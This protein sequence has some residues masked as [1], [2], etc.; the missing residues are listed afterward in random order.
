M[1]CN[2]NFYE[3][4]EDKK[5]R[6]KREKNNTQQK[7]KKQQKYVEKRYK[8]RISR[9][10]A[11]MKETTDTY[12]PREYEV[13]TWTIRSHNG[14]DE[15]GNCTGKLCDGKSM[16]C[17]MCECPQYQRIIKEAKA[18]GRYSVECFGCMTCIKDSPTKNWGNNVT[19]CLVQVFSKKMNYQDANT[20]KLIIEYLM[21]PPQR[22]IFNSWYSDEDEDGLVWNYA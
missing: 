13:E 7:R 3:Y 2:R 15:Y 1:A 4:Y 12:F 20:V 18:E 19:T 16:L 5:S 6:K 9:E 17:S 11:L 10:Y 8:K 21:T 14:L 22:K